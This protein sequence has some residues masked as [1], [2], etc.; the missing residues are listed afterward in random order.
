MESYRVAGI[1][2]HKRMLAVV[3][4]D[5]AVEGEVQFERQKFGTMDSD[6]RAL[7]AWLKERE[8][9]EAV[10]E[11]TAQ[12][13]KPVWRQL[14]GQCQLHLAQAQ[15]NRAPRGRKS[16]FRDAER[17]T[18]RHIAGELILS[19]VPD[20][21]QRLWRTLTRTRHQLTRERVR[22]QNQL[23][24]LLEDA[25]I[26]LGSCVSDLL[27]VSSRRMLKALASGE[28]DPAR[29]ARL[30]DPALRATPE[31]LRDALQA[32]A[33]MSDLHRK[34]LELFLDRLKLVEGQMEILAE[35]IAGA[36]QKH[37]QAVMRL[38]EV[39]GFGVDSAQQV[40]AEV[41]P[42]AATFA[43]AGE[44]ASWVGV[45]PGNQ[46][47]AEVSQSSRSPKGNRPMRRVLTQVAN[48]AVKA[49]GT[50]FQALY[51]RHMPRLGHEGAV[52][53]VA[54]RLCR[55]T[56]KIL[57]QGV[58]YEERGN[59]PNPKAVRRR[60]TRLIRKFRELGYAVQLTPIAGQ[61]TP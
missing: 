22:L 42:Q 48:A 15:S 40:I 30:A 9:R 58:S 34:I 54:H 37:R 12:Y 8:V 19:F 27:G 52:W 49:K 24:A 5:A 13:W 56:W 28:T 41:G 29:L 32:A 35:S 31:Q 51:R 16:D 50:V 20:P 21:E 39:P 4:T 25:R 33:T 17:L 26:K 59:R 47:S 11:S 18:R 2:V 60:T 55:L 43:S 57:H 38:A 10:M 23:E 46:E 36:L 44:L 14:E 7:A 6:L 53:L 1:D 3:V 45:C 61:A